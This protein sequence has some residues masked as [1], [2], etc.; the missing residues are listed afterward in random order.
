MSDDIFKDCPQLGEDRDRSQHE[1]RKWWDEE[2]A[3]WYKAAPPAYRCSIAKRIRCLDWWSNDA[4][5]LIK[6]HLSELRIGYVLSNMFTRDGES[7]LWEP[8]IQVEGGGCKTPDFLVRDHGGREAIVEVTRKRGKFWSDVGSHRIY[9]VIRKRFNE[10]MDIHRK[11]VSYWSLC[12]E[13][14]ERKFR[15]SSVA[16]LPDEEIV[17]MVDDVFPRIWEWYQV[18]T[19]SDEP[20]YERFAQERFPFGDVHVTVQAYKHDKPEIARLFETDTIPSEVE[21]GSPPGSELHT[22]VE[23]KV[24]K[25]EKTGKP[26]IVVLEY[27]DWSAM[28]EDIESVLY[29]ADRPYMWLDSWLG[30]TG[31]VPEV[32]LHAPVLDSSESIWSNDTTSPLVAVVFV[33][34]TVGLPMASDDVTLYL[35]PNLPRH[36]SLMPIPFPFLKEFGVRQVR[37]VVMDVVRR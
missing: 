4:E 26:I 15:R 37:Q 17:Q 30:G 32:S 18:V 20:W 13:R 16:C 35:R 3:A 14:G 21:S 7:V 11:G 28:G 33:R 2:V 36:P 25:Y 1:R 5:R 9:D 10:N 29:G 22:K 12:I 8:K 34:S 6:S 31:M 19:T 27:G 23:E 24:C